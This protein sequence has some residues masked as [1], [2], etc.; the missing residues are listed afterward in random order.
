MWEILGSHH[1][2]TRGMVFISMIKRTE[3]NKIFILYASFFS[4][5]ICLHC[6]SHL[7]LHSYVPIVPWLLRACYELWNGRV[8]VSRVIQNTFNSI[9]PLIAR[10]KNIYTP[11]VALVRVTF[12]ERINNQ[13]VWWSLPA[14]VVFK[15]LN[16]DY[17]PR[18]SWTEA[19]SS[20]RNHVKD[21][22]S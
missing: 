9:D 11:L 4:S 14:S 20:K 1:R 15:L 17:R 13:T 10:I 22:R 5:Q 7:V 3:K 12:A 2:R 16:N 18:K 19:Q 21:P 8:F 6:F